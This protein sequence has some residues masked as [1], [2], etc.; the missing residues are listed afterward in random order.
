MSWNNID[1]YQRPNLLF[2]KQ[3]LLEFVVDLKNLKIFSTCANFSPRLAENEIL[4]EGL[5]KSFTTSRKTYIFPE[6]KY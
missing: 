2:V 4:K 6:N 5:K 1:L 3:L